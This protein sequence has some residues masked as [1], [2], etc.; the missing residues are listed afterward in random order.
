MLTD[1]V[2]KYETNKKEI[3]RKIESLSD[4]VEEEI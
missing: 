1:L 2:K 4:K 3:Q